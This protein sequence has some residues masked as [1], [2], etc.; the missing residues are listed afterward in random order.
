MPVI[1]KIFRKFNVYS[2]ADIIPTKYDHDPKIELDDNLLEIIDKFS[3]T[4]FWERKLTDGK[5]NII[6]QFKKNITADDIR[7]I[8]IDK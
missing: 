1:Q 3:N 8:Y 6:K 5:W 2:S 7:E 4:K